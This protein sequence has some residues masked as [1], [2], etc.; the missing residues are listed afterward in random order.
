MRLLLAKIED[1]LKIIVGALKGK[2]LDY[3]LRSRRKKV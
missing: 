1:H 2:N 3:L